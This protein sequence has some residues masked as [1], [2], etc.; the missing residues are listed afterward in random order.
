MSVK[1]LDVV[2][3]VYVF[4]GLEMSYTIELTER[5]KRNMLS[6][7]HVA[8]GS[9]YSLKKIGWITIFTIFFTILG[10]FGQLN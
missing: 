5:W 6:H 3:M 4:Y 2:D 10:F 9:I 7:S 8:F 1:G